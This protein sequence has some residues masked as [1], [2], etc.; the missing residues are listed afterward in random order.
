[1]VIDRDI[2]SILGA[3]YSNSGSTP[4]RFGRRRGDFERDLEAALRHIRSSGTFHETIETGVV[5]AEKTRHTADA[6]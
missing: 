4:Q 3:V 1:M 6:R 5:V 2:P